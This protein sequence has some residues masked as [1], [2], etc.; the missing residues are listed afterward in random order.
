MAGLQLAVRQWGEA[1]GAP[2]LALHGWLD[3]AASFDAMGPHLGGLHVCAMDFAGHGLSG[4]RPAGVP[5]HLIDNV[6]DAVGVADAMGWEKFS[7]LAHSMG[8]GVGALLAGAFPDRVT[9][10]VFLDG[11]GPLSSPGAEAPGNLRKAVRLMLR[12]RPGDAAAFATLEDCAK[13]RVV[14]GH[15]PI[16][17][18]A[19][20]VLCARNVRQTDAGFEWRTDARLRYRS[21]LRLTEE[22][23][24]AFIAAIEAPMLL[25]QASEGLAQFSHRF[26]Q[27]LDAARNLR[28]ETVQGGHHCHLEEQSAPVAALA[29]AFIG[30][31]LP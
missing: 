31:G 3:N 19:A 18:D 21:M 12:A 15:T 22:Q 11:F 26:T 28:V 2:V 27:R 14:G 23:V 4:H 24:C 17:V 10:C 29:T 5:Y 1:T 13:A 20:R 16:S 6:T 30:A 9:S 25:V 7:L 8:A